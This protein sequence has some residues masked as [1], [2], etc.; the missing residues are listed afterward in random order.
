MRNSK[1][2]E[3]VA[4]LRQSGQFVAIFDK[5]NQARGSASQR[6]PPFSKRAAVLRPILSPSNRVNKPR[7]P[8][9]IG[10]ENVFHKHADGPG[11]CIQGIVERHDAK[12]HQVR[13]ESV[14][15]FL[16]AFIAVIAVNPQEPDGPVPGTSDICR[17]LNMR[18][19]LICYASGLDGAEKVL[20]RGCFRIGLMI[21]ENRRIVRINGDNRA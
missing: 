18:F 1:A 21:Q 10:T 5:W 15:I 14:Q 3:F 2:I 13:K 12:G 6:R 9:S 17:V 8:E 11:K 4:P 19:H 20:I 7:W 16:G